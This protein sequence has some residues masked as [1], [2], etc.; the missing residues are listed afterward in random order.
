MSRIGELPIPIPSGVKAMPSATEVRVEGPKGK[1]T[2][3]LPRGISCAVEGETLKLSRANNSKSMRALHGLARALVANAVTGI[4][5]GF[6]KKL[7]I[8]GI[9]YRAQLQGTEL[10]MTLGFSHPVI[11]KV[12]KTVTVKVEGQNKISI[13]G[14][15]RQAVGQVAAEIRALKPPEPYKGKGIRYVGEQVKRKVGKTGA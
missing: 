14:I 2:Q 9:G 15:D 3:T 7:Q 5:T 1:M 11:Y 4:T 8:E 10:N 6:M 13:S 12:P